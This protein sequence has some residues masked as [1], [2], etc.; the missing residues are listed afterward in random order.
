VYTIGKIYILVTSLRLPPS[1]TEGNIT[2]ETHRFSNGAKMVVVRK[3][4]PQQWA[5]EINR[6]IKVRD[7]NKKRARKL[8]Y[9]Y[10]ER[11][12]SK[13]M[14][15]PIIIGLTAIILLLSF[16]G[17]KELGKLALSWL[18]SVTIISTIVY[19]MFKRFEAELG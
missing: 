18:V 3:V 13:L 16:Y 10:Y 8:K 9:R 2:T 5:Y 17:W 11:V 14:P 1:A 19:H 12:L 15:V 7:T 6:A 4:T